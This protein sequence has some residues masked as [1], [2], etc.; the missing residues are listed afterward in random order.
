MLVDTRRLEDSFQAMDRLEAGNVPFVVA[1]NNFPDAPLHSVA[2]LR[3]ALDLG[4]DV[5][6]VNCD[7]RMLE[8]SRDVLLTLMRYLYT[9]ATQA[10]SE[11][12]R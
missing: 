10:P 1:V 3:S 4:E 8:S 11:V 6:L 2:A 12:T 5:P 7:A 9:N